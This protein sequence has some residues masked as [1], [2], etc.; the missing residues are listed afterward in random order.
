MKATTF[1]GGYRVPMIAQMPGTIPAGIVSDEMCGTI[2]LFPTVLQRCNVDL[3]QDRVIDGRD[4]WPLLTESQARTPHEA[5]FCMMHDQLCTVRSGKWKLHVVKPFDKP[6]FISNPQR[7][8]LRD[9]DGVTIIA[10]HE[11]PE[12]DQFPGVDRGD[13]PTAPMLFDLDNDPAEQVN[14]ATQRP[15]VV[16]RLKSLYDR[17][18]RQIDR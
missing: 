16:I 2:D 4:I 11:Q 9:P 8:S 6:G 13:T 12:P 1:E 10:Q 14:L 3:P 7:L 5:L 15:D 17:M 18:N